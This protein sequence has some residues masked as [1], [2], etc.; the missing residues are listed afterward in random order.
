MTKAAGNE[1]VKLEKELERTGVALDSVLNRYH[2]ES[3][4]QI[5]EE[6]Y[7][8]AIEC[9]KKSKSKRGCI[10]QFNKIIGWRKQENGNKETKVNKVN[11]ADKKSIQEMKKN[12]RKITS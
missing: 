9:L 1:H 4:E 3:A 11:K 12:E 8:K 2:L 10:G 6:I 5:S 7:K